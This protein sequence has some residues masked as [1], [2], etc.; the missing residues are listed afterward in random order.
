MMSAGTIEAQKLT[1]LN[2]PPGGIFQVP[3]AWLE[4]VGQRWPKTGRE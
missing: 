2:I 1:W 3:P 4:Q